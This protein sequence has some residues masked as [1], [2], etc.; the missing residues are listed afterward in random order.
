MTTKAEKTLQRIIQAATLGRL[1]RQRKP[2]K[3]YGP[4]D[5]MMRRVRRLRHRYESSEMDQLFGEGNW[6]GKSLH[7]LKTALHADKEKS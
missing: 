3:V 6:Q 5:S 4:E 7:E 2:R 1:S